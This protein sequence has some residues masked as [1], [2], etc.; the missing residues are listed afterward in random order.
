MK[1]R[2]RHLRL[3]AETQK[4]RFGADIPLSDGLMVL[5][6]DNSR[7]KSTSMQS[8]LFALGLERMIT[9]RP[10]NAVTSAMRDRLIFD[11]DTKGETPVL[12]SW[13]SLEIEGAS[14]D[15]ATL[16]RWVKHE[17]ID[18]GLVR[19]TSGPAL[20]DPGDYE[21][22]DY[23]VGRS[24]AVAN[25]RGFHR[26]LSSFMGWQLPELPASDGRSVPLYMEQVFPLIFVEQ[27]RGWGGIQ[28]QMPYF[29]G[30]SDVKRR[31]IEFLMKLDVGRIES[32]RL[33]LR[34]AD[35]RV[36]EKWR[37]LVKTF[38]DS[39]AGHGLLAVRLPTNLTISWPPTEMPFV[40]ESREDTWVPLDNV[41]RELHREIEIIEDVPVSEVGES[42]GEL[43]QQLAE[44]GERSDLLRQDIA[45]LRDEVLQDNSELRQVQS[46]LEALQED[47]REH[48][49]ILT[50][51]RLGSESI[52][53]IHGDCPV[54]H[55]NIPTSL[56]ATV[57]NVQT[58]STEE[59]VN[60]IRQQLDLF[61]TMERDT[62]LTVSAKRERLAS[63]RRQS[64]ELHSRIRSIR[65]T[66]TS[67]DNTPSEEDIAYKVRLRDRVNDL[68]SITERFLQLLGEL[69]RVAESGR[70]IRSALAGLPKDKIS[71]NDKRK[72]KYLE[73]S[74]ISQLREYDFG[75]FS[76][77]RLGISTIDFLPRRDDFDLQADISAS[78]SIRV[79]WAYLLGLL[80]TSENFDTNH[81]RLLIFD[82]PRQQSA[83]EMS[84]AALL[85]RASADSDNRQIIF[86]TSED[87]SSLQR[88]LQGVEHTLH[89]IEGYVLKAVQ[90]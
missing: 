52:S 12:S 54:C 28:A 90:E 22:Q 46:R 53:R 20:T 59:T 50:L 67:P 32:E 66:L 2:F 38:N 87:L 61:T 89:P 26:W 72:L 4:G 30:V 88:M 82:E 40:A 36:Q 18:S 31:A 11:S 10:S 17:D 69:D 14:G 76:D 39:I 71:E 79:V 49:D 78:D 86:A 13:V 57:S 74:F 24:G 75:S 45:L 64:A 55:Q 81:P 70:E 56:L 43:E 42:A 33:R 48:Q 27:R 60:Y 21:V 41:I 29:S 6:A 73:G 77:E 80:E 62:Q 47:L 3:R 35:K 65:S 7:G 25:P 51:E 19:V 15:I 84:F 37:D 85:K 34:A 83:K 44:A 16:T 8:F 23:Y 1:L 9:A 63:L 58:L 5:R 68:G